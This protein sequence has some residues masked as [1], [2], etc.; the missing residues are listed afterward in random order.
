MASRRTYGDRFMARPRHDAMSY[1]LL[2]SQRLAT[3]AERACEQCGR[4]VQVRILEDYVEG[5]PVFRLFCLDCSEQFEPGR[6]LARPRSNSTVLFILAAVILLPL[7]ILERVA[8][9]YVRSRRQ[10][11]RR[12]HVGEPLK[13]IPREPQPTPTAITGRLEGKRLAGRQDYT[14]TQPASPR[15]AAGIYSYVD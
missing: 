11:R 1:P 2:P 9:G 10:G 14:R 6:H 5:R 8:T 4:P 15:E 7:M 3:N 12:L 13:S